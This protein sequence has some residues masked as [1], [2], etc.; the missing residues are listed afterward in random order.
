[1]LKKSL[2]RFG[3]CASLS[4]L[5]LGTGPS[6]PGSAFAG[7]TVH[8]T[9][10]FIRLTQLRLQ[11]R[12]SPSVAN[13]LSGTKVHRTFVLA[14]FARGSLARGVVQGGTDYGADGRKMENTVSRFLH[15]SITYLIEKWQYV[16]DLRADCC[17]AATC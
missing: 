14:R 11:A 5:R 6:P 13:P 8:W 7:T 10:L 3:P 16:R 4:L 2:L 1:M 9:V 17:F 12:G 15:F